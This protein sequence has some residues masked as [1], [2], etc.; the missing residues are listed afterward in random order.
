[1]PGGFG[2]LSCS[3]I[4]TIISETGGAWGGNTVCHSMDRCERSVSARALEVSVA[5]VPVTETSKV[6]SPA[7]S[8]QRGLSLAP[9]ANHPYLS[10][11]RRAAGG[12]MHERIR[13]RRSVGRGT[14]GRGGFGREIACAYSN[15]CHYTNPGAG[16]RTDLDTDTR[17]RRPPS[18]LLCRPRMEDGLLET[19]GQVFRNHRRKAAARRHPTLRRSRILSVVRC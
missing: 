1:M 8:C 14:R 2:T 3:A 12:G 5:I 7:R 15:T 16:S 13:N 9:S 10:P 19:L 6:Q 4:S 17:G 11:A 18:A